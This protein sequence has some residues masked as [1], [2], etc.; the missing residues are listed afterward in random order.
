MAG[1]VR[2]KRTTNKHRLIITALRYQKFDGTDKF[3]L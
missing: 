2:K 3:S 1:V